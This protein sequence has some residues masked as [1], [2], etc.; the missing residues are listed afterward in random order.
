MPKQ[1]EIRKKMRTILIDWLIQVQ[2]RFTLLQETLYLTVYIIDRFLDVSLCL[3]SFSLRK[4]IV[5]FL[6]R[7]N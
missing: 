5:L 7:G 4:K 1:T 2:C 6:Q 3:F